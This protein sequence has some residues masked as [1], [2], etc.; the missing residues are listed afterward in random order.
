[1]PHWTMPQFV[2]ALISRYYFE[3]RF[4]TKRWK[5]YATVLSA[6]YACGM[7]LVGMGSVAIAMVQKSVSLLPY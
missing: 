2:G 7:G 4:G 3:K 1:M 6:G 5:Q